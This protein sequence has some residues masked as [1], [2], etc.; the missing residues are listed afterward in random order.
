MTPHGDRRFG[1]RMDARVDA[2]GCVLGPGGRTTGAVFRSL[3]VD[4]SDTGLRMRADR[5]MW[6][7]DRVH[8]LC[9]LD[10]DPA[11]LVCARVIWSRPSALS[12]IGRT[13]AGLRL[14]PAGQTGAVKLSNHCRAARARDTPVAR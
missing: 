3:V 1:D 10:E 4:V 2:I 13:V 8:V 12:L 5:P 11:A 6:R 14:D 7:G 9:R